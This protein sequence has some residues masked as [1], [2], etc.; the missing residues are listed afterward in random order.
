MAEDSLKRPVTG[1]Q[2]SVSDPGD[3][4]PRAALNDAVLSLPEGSPERRL[5]ARAVA[6]LTDEQLGAESIRQHFQSLFDAVPDAVT[7]LDVDGVVIEA[8]GSACQ[9]FA[10]SREQLIGLSVYDLNPA[11]P[12]DRVSRVIREHGDGQPFVHPTTNLR[13]D[14]TQFPVEVHSQVFLHDGRPVSE[15]VAAESELRASEARYR[16]LLQVMD[17]GVLVQDDR[18][19]VVSVNPS[20][21]RM[22]GREE[23]EL[24]DDAF[25]IGDWDFV[26][27]D[28]PRLP[29][30]E[31]PPVRALREGRT[32]ESATIGVFD[33]LQRRYIWVAVTS[34]PL[35]RDDCSTPFSVISTFSDVSQLKRDSELFLETQE[36]A[37]IGGWE[38]EPFV[39]R[40][41][42]TAPPYRLLDLEPGADV[43]LETLIDAVQPAERHG[44]EAALRGAETHRG[45]FDL[46]CQIRSA[47]GRRRWVRLL[48]E[49][50][51]RQGDVFRIVGTLQDITKDKLTEAALRQRALTDPLTGLANRDAI[52][53]HIGLVV[54]HAEPASGPG[55]LHID[56][57]R[58][59]VVNDLLGHQGGDALLRM[60]GERLAATVGEQGVAARF[61]GDEFLVLNMAGGSEVALELAERIA[62]AFDSPFPYGGEEFSITSSVGVACYPVDGA[63]VQQLLHHADA[64]MTRPSGAVATHGRP[65]PLRSRGRC[66]IAWSSRHSCA[67]R[68]RTV[69][70]IWSISPRWSW[71]MAACVVS[72]RCCDGT[73]ACS[74]R[75]HRTCS[76]RLPRP[77]ATS[78]A[79]GHG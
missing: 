20:A 25:S 5:L 17:K 39:H 70:S 54:D 73:T 74:G 14:G 40:M 23:A 79:S 13:A 57:D 77:P 31:L 65:S 68:W 19:R 36:L 58:F 48:G 69:S 34:T 52:V 46:E 61:S 59:K 62:H 76:S 60:A 6:A 3:A 78:C 72:R 47:R 71:P 10:R 49:G 26:D 38:W 44:V 16:E 9:V 35:F 53:E 66:P 4:L 29:A 27:V 67:V 24:L 7:V 51:H 8:N 33:L 18:G 50:Q 1:S 55:V 15:R 63:T 45:S 21:C 56:L 41:H 32:I 28:G 43:S 11:L 37:R 22:L 30:R 64:A 12:R 75:W 2:P 42:F